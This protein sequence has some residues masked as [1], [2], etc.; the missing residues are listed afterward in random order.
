MLGKFDEGKNSFENGLL[1]RYRDDLRD[2]EIAYPDHASLRKILSNSMFFDLEIILLHTVLPI[3]NQ[4]EIRKCIEKIMVQSWFNDQVDRDH[5]YSPVDD[6]LT[7]NSYENNWPSYCMR[8]DFDENY[9][10]HG[11]SVDIHSHILSYGNNIQFANAIESL[12][13]HVHNFFE[14]APKSQDVLRI[15]FPPEVLITFACTNIVRQWMSAVRLRH[16]VC[17]IADILLG[18]TSPL[19]PF[20]DCRHNAGQSA[21]R[22]HAFISYNAMQPE[23]YYSQH[24]PQPNRAKSR[25]RC[26]SLRNFWDALP[27]I[28]RSLPDV[29][30]QTAKLA[31]AARYSNTPPPGFFIH[32][33]SNRLACETAASIRFDILQD[34]P[35][36]DLA[37]QQ[38]GAYHDR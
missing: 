6:P 15:M 7:L 16:Y 23:S 8:L 31:L 10:G 2:G 4:Q 27:H 20:D 35:A 30:F 5:E 14:I 11:F 1:A 12:R 38:Y 34:R 21:R 9:V 24:S 32:N 36:V 17:A 18:Y 13:R 19:H 33:L 28:F 26:I 3:Q 22:A 25:D 29:K 37:V